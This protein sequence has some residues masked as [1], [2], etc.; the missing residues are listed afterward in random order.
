LDNEIQQS[1][2]NI[3]NG[4]EAGQD[5]AASHTNEDPNGGEAQKNANKRNQRKRT[6]NVWEHFDECFENG[7]RMVICKG[8]RRKF[9]RSKSCSTTGMKNHWNSCGKGKASKNK[10]KVDEIEVR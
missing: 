2:R 5:T 6:S 10:Q 4:N 1:L 9:P 7:E 3:E 8:C